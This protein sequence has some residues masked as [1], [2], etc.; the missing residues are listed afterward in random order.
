M[1]DRVIALILDESKWFAASLAAALLLLPLYLRRPAVRQWPPRAR[2][3][4]ALMLLFAATIGAMA[5]GHLLAV[6]TKL[7]LGTLAGPAL[8]LYLLGAA[9]AVPSWW[10]LGR[11]WRGRTPDD[12]RFVTLATWTVVTLLVLGVRT[13][14]LAVPGILGIAYSFHARR[15]VGWM[16]AGTALLAYAGLLTGALLFMARGGSFEDFSGMR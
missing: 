12:A 1:P 16:I 7:V 2:V 9:L 4:G 15:A 13:L 8:P 14:P 6:T 11:T 3:Q 10:L 5:F